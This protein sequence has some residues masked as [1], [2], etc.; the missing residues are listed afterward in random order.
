M[1]FNKKTT[2]LDSGMLSGFTDYHCHLLP[3][4]DDGVKE[5]RETLQLL[6]LWEEH[7][8]KEIWLTPH[9]MEDIPNTTAALRQRF[10]DLSAAYKG[11]IVLHLAAEHILD[12]L[13]LERI[14]KDDVLPLGPSGS[15]QLLVET[16]YFNPPMDMEHIIDKMKERAYT[17]IL[18]HPERYQYMDI[19]DYRH[20]KERGM[21]FQLNVP[22]LVGAYGPDVQKK[23]EMLLKRGMYNLCGTDTHSIR[24]ADYFLHSK[25]NKKISRNL[26]DYL[27]V[28]IQI[29]TFV[30]EK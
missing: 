7:G 19:G 22:S 4:V 18:A 10:D 2:V 25:I 14:E 23:A 5:L 30:P 17:P 28:S 20:W 6:S 8:V 13:F 3:G 27:D 11:P 12:N 21:L 9:I 26:E 1:M 16:S 15:R 29:S 24:F